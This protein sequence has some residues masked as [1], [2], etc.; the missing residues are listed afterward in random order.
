MRYAVVSSTL[1]L[2]QLQA[3]VLRHGGSGIKVANYSEQVFTDLDDI[4][5]VKLRQLP[6]VHITTIAKVTTP[7]QMS[8]IA[9]PLEVPPITRPLGVPIYGLRYIQEL[10]QIYALSEIVTPPAVAKGYTVAILDSGIRKTHFALRDKVIYEKNFTDSPTCE[11]IYDH[12]T[13]V[14]Y[15]M[16]GGRHVFGEESGMSPGVNILNLKVL[17]DDGVGTEESCVMA[18]EH[19]MALQKE[20]EAAGANPLDPLWTNMINCSWGAEDQGNPNN[21]IRV[22]ARRAVKEDMRISITASAGNQGPR[23]GTIS[24]PAAEYCVWAVGGVTVDPFEIWQYSSRGPTKEGLIKPDNVFYCENLLL[25]SSKSD[26]AFA[27][28]SGTSFAAPMM[29]SAALL[30]KELWVCFTGNM[31][32]FYWPIEALYEMTKGICVKPVG[33]PVEKD[34]N[35]GDGMVFGS[36]L[37]QSFQPTAPAM[38]IQALMSQVT[39]I[40]SLAMLAMIIKGVG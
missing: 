19:V 35:V 18:L 12:G 4:G 26:T 38:D 2:S 37:A 39:P 17:D 24:V 10:S 29:C 32:M 7:E 23:E 31:D 34:N 15:V 22:A 3:E 11:D 40:M 27:I 5:V 30:A 9:P 20:R 28:K 8:V 36:L 33:A 14:A 1:T 21:P 6:G 25:A 13:A 16:A